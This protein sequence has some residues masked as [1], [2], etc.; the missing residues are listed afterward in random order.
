MKIVIASCQNKY[1]GLGQY[2]QHLA[3]AFDQQGIETQVYRK[4]DAEPPLFRAYPYRSFKSL[5]PY[6]APYYL[7]R[8]LRSEQADIWQ[9]DYVDAA[10]GALLA[11]KKQS[12]FVTHAFL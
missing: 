3:T 6:V 9:T 1:C 8:S 10:M 12:L 7:S 11:Q 5:R 4:D 2:T